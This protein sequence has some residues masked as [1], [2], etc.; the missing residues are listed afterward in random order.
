MELNMAPRGFAASYVDAALASIAG[1]DADKRL[2]LLT[3]PVSYAS[4]VTE[5]ITLSKY[6]HRLNMQNVARTLGLSVRS[7][8]RRLEAERTT[9]QRLVNEA[10][11]RKACHL[12]RLDPGSVQAVA[13]EMGFADSSSFQRA[14]KRWTGMT[15]GRFRLQSRT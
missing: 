14:F 13:F 9:Y 11:A 5:Q 4:R 15:P 2:L 6:G 7:L 8:R 10:L 1:P 12:L 3:L